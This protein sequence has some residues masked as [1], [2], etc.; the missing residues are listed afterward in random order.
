MSKLTTWNCFSLTGGDWDPDLDN[1]DLD[2]ISKDDLNDL[3][4][5]I[6]ITAAAG[7]VYLEYD[8][9]ATDAEDVTTHPYK[10]RPDDYVDAGVWIEKEPAKLVAD[11]AVAD[12]GTGASTLTDHAILLGSGTDPIT[13]LAVLGA[14]EIVVGVAGADPHALQQELQPRYWL[15]V[16][17]AIQC[18]QRQLV[19][20]LR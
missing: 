14:G 10:V 13:P 11:L 5:A 3:D 7:I 19:Q 12:G 15:G 2:G 4:R 18:G 17:Q 8:A 16:V 1:R 20:V 9:A 6:V